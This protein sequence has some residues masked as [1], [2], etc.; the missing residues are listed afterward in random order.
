MEEQTCLLS[1]CG[2]ECLCVCR[3]ALRKLTGNYL[4]QATRPGDDHRRPNVIISFFKLHDNEMTENIR[5]F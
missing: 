4:K 2:S 5:A 3:R 1:I